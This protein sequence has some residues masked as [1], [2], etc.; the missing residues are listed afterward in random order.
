[1]KKL[2]L[3]IAVV[4]VTGVITPAQ[5]DWHTYPFREISDLLSGEQKLYR[6]SGSRG[7]IVISGKPFPAKTRVTYTG[8]KRP[9]GHYTKSFIKIWVSTRNV[10]A[11]VSDMFVEEY[12]FKEK[13]VE[14]WLPVQS[15]VAPSLSAELKPGDEVIIYYF[16]L[17][18][19]NGRSLQQK[20]TANDKPTAP[21]PDALRWMLAV[22]RVE[23]PRIDFQEQALERSIDRSMEEPGKITDV[24]YDPRQKKAKAKLVFTGDV[25]E[26]SGK[27]KKLRDLWFENY[28]IPMSAAGLMQSEAKFRDG[29]KEYWILMRTQTLEHI[30]ENVGKGGSL[31][32]NTILAGAVRNAGEIDWVFF[33]GEYSR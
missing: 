32:L 31:L 27:R 2:L 3:A 24:W 21:E 11:P 22:E 4:V 8:E 19:F 17:G 23:K 15:N 28:G 33:A 25:R 20:D 14:Y 1:M 13:G 7:D 26:V 30:R 9:A 29:E 5:D 16:Y 18:G 12:L 6:D 10:P